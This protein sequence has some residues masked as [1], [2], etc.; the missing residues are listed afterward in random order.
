MLFQVDG[1]SC[2]H[3]ASTIRAAIRAL[4]P[5]AR[6]EVDLQAGT[7]RVTGGVEVDSAAEAIRNEGYPVRAVGR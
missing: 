2:G 4:D 7:V 5:D 1:M 6:V 3:C